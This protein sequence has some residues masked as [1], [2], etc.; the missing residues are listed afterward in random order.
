MAQ[1][2]VLLQDTRNTLALSE[3]R[4]IACVGVDD[5][6]VVETADTILVA[7]KNKTQDVKKTIDRLKVTAWKLR[8]IRLSGAGF[9]SPK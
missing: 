4:L 2:D 6:I 1:G 8:S 5:L 9:I 3:G 7:H